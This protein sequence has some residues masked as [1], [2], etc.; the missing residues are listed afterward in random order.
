ML[1]M[2]ELRGVLRIGIEISTEKNKTKLLDKMLLKAM[3]ISG[4]DAGTLYLCKEGKLEFKIMKTLS[5]GVSRGENGESIDL[6]PVELREENVCAYSAIR[7]ELVNIPDVYDSD[8]FD[9]SGPKRYDGITGYRTK[10]MLVIPME[11]AEDRVI[12]VLQLI[13]KL[14]ESGKVIGFTD[15]DA[16]V[17]R[18]L[19]SMA[20]VSLSNMIY[21]QQIQLQMGSFVQ[22]FA[23]AVDKRTPYNGSHTRKVTI[24]A[25]LVAR[26]MNSL[27]E[28]GEG[29]ECFD[30][31]RTEQLKLAAGLHDIGKMIVPL[32]IMNKST[33][34]DEGLE[35][36]KSRFDYI[37]LLYERDMLRGDISPETY[38]EKKAE[39]EDARA[40]V[41]A[42]DGAGFL[43]DEML[44]KVEG[45]SAL[46]YRG[47]D[48][49]E[50]PYL[51]DE[52]TVCLK[53]RKGTLTA[54]ERKV[55]ESHA[56]M[57]RTILEQ[58]YFTEKYA[59]APKFA[60]EHHELLDGSGY[61]DR[62]VAEQLE[63][64]TRILTVVD[65]FDALTCTDRPYKKP[66][67]RDRAISILYSMVDEGK[68]D[69]YIVQMLEGALVGVSEADIEQ[70]ASESFSF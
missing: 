33:R 57:T 35:R 65:V 66:I 11:D 15:D 44:A 30:E 18:S 19:G 62:L 17:L 29:G 32:S 69:R 58:V 47:V 40:T 23:T 7:R 1:K 38:A 52:E 10:S 50:I 41:L 3:D 20:A 26:Y 56:E 6:P 4:C 51:T 13:N 28:K 60:S 14:D 54:D 24:Y 68:M 36:V 39:L 64:E 16:F 55:M 21:L 9:F 46:V 70:R 61:P 5:Q 34:L 42:A 59:K 63:T 12:G 2:S 67:P 25:E 49:R 43:P 45:V 31:A 22:A 37:G 48:G 53:V 27:Y 8:K